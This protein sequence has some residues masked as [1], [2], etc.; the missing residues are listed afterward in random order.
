M[1]PFSE[2]LPT[3]TE[4]LLWHELARNPRR[5]IREA[6]F[7]LVADKIVSTV[8]A[9]RLFVS[10]ET[11]IRTTVG[12]VWYTAA[13][14]GV[15]FLVIW[16]VYS[17]DDQ[18]RI[19]GGLLV[20][21][22]WI[23]L[24][25]GIGFLL[26]PRV[27]Q[28]LAASRGP[29]T[30]GRLRKWGVK[31]RE[32]SHQ[33]FTRPSEMTMKEMESRG[34][35]QATHPTRQ[36]TSFRD[37]Q[38]VLHTFLGGSSQPGTQPSPTDSVGTST[39]ID[40]DRAIQLFSKQLAAN[41]SDFVISDETE[42]MSQHW[43]EFL[44]TIKGGA[45]KKAEKITPA[46]YPHKQAGLTKS[47][48]PKKTPDLSNYLTILRRGDLGPYWQA[49]YELVRDGLPIVYRLPVQKW[50][51][52]P[53]YIW[54][55][56]VVQNRQR[57]PHQGAAICTKCG[58]RVTSVSVPMRGQ[59]RLIFC[60]HCQTDDQ[61][62]PVHREVICVVDDPPLDRLVDGHGNL[63][64]PWSLYRRPFAFDRVLIRTVNVEILIQF[65]EEM[66]AGKKSKSGTRHS[67]PCMVEFPEKIPAPV[68]Q[69][70]KSL[71][72]YQ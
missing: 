58:Q 11:L 43:R 27:A 33:E 38:I 25:V 35:P 42:K 66:E 24:G 48:D 16:L 54:E 26:V 12:V 59:H 40:L 18:A 5:D 14:T 61:L 2:I 13:L 6:L 62:Q 47:V 44:N 70:L 22:A 31:I 30:Y 15:P 39:F 20:F 1:S 45:L 67:I 63:Y 72:Q 65:M 46:S 50:K 32:L 60:A 17:G 51:Q 34:S 64:F 28:F 7:Q 69:R 4:K 68:L 19:F 53:S 3:E 52:I 36:M 21:G 41:P 23:L 55:D 57:V 29:W 49:R 8:Q 56:L 9:K 37:L 71:F 10:S